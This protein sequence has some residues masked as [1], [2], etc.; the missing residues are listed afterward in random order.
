VTVVDRPIPE[1]GEDGVLIRVVAAG[2][3][4]LD[5]RLTRAEPAMVRLSMGLRA[6]RDERLGEDVSGIV[7]QVGSAV[8]QFAPGDAV[9]GQATG[10][11]AEYVVAHERHLAHAPANLPLDEAAA[12]SVAGVTALQAI[13]RG[14]SIGAASRVLVIGA[15][16][17]V[18]SYCVQIAVSLGAHV[19][20]VCSTTSVDYVRRLGAHRVIDY[21]TE[22]LDGQYDLIVELAVGGSLRS[23]RRLLAPHGVLVLSSGDGGALW[24][25]LPRIAASA[26][27]P[28]VTVL[29]SVTRADDLRE[30][31]RLAGEGSI[32]PV[33]VERFPLERAAEAIARVDRGF[34]RGKVLVEIGS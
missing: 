34:S 33:V 20:G 31:A 24:G 27:S 17:G 29:S 12:L 28:Q 23:I 15:A 3:N 14:G 9:F 6:P 7:T 22:S 26:F 1:V 8:T 18:G 5:W 4:S 19:T 2:L 16:G 11:I 30:V 21:R 25:P 10:S 32:A 13:R